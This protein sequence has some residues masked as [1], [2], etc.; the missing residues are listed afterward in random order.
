VN[1]IKRHYTV[2]ILAVL[3][4][5][6][7]SLPQFLLKQDLGKDYAGVY[8]SATDSEMYY[9]GRIRDIYDGH[10][11]LS[12]A[13]LAEYKDLPYIQPPVPEIITAG[14]GYFSFSSDIPTRIHFATRFVIPAILILAVYVFVY[15]VTGSRVQGLLG[16]S[17]IVL[18]LELLHNFR[19][20][21]RVLQLEFTN[22]AALV[23]SRPVSPQMGVLFFFLYSIVFWEWLT[24]KK[25]SFLWA[26]GIL[27][28]FSTYIYFYTWA[29]I[30]AANG[31]LGLYFLYQKN[32]KD[33]WKL[34]GIHIIALVVS[35]PY[36]FNFYQFY[37]QP[38]SQFLS[39]HLG[40]FFS[41]RFFMNWSTVGGLVLLFLTQRNTSV[42][43]VWFTSLLLGGFLAVNQQVITGRELTPAHFHWYFISVIVGLVVLFAIF[44]FFQ[45][46]SRPKLKVVVSLLIFVFIFGY[47]FLRQNNS[48]SFYEK[49]YEQEQRFGKLYKWLDENTPVDSVVLVADRDRGDKIS[50]F[51][52]NNAYYSSFMFLSNTPIERLSDMHNLNLRLIG[53]PED[54]SKTE[55]FLREN[56]KLVADFLGGLSTRRIYGCRTCF[57]EEEYQKAA[58]VYNKYLKIDLES[59][60]SKYRLDYIVI[61]AMNDTWG[62]EGLPGVDILAELED[63]KIY[64]YDSE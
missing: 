31:F 21:F 1:L 3:V 5:L 23:F 56:P 47:A 58:E 11:K 14:L 35:V 18:G 24:K 13:F 45:L 26:S 25:K 48:Y 28:G 30:L 36:L 10:F 7:M 57:P 62:P 64:S 4:G 63:F 60:L 59:Q 40:Q 46:E 41:N 49:G 8:F 39:F 37:Q 20:V 16:A 53:G 33:F 54:P 34:I 9:T 2:I 19:E 17:L 22:N 12:N 52:H 29:F 42:R 27:L 51:T 6:I 50:T 55:D 44:K 38:N 61:D 15:R 32:F 43:F